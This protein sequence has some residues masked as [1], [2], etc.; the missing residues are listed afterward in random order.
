MSF[1]DFTTQLYAKCQADYV[2]SSQLE[3]VRFG[4]Y[5]YDAWDNSRKE[6]VRIARR[7]FTAG[8][9]SKIFLFQKL[10]QSLASAPLYTRVEINTLTEDIDL[11]TYFERKCPT[12][13]LDQPMLKIVYIP[14]G[15]SYI[16]GLDALPDWLREYE[17]PGAEAALKRSVTHFLKIFHI[18][19]NPEEHTYARTIIFTSEFDCTFLDKMYTMYMLFLDINLE[20]PNITISDDQKG[21][22]EL[23][24]AIFTKLYANEDYA[25]ALGE[26]LTR[27]HAYCSK[28][29]LDYTAF[30]QSLEKML[31]IKQTTELDQNITN[32][33][34]S[35]ER[36]TEELQRLYANLS[37]AHYKKVS[38]KGGLVDFTPF[39]DFI[40]KS[41]EM[42]ILRA[43][44]DS[45]TIRVDTVL[46]YFDVQH[47]NILKKNRSGYLYDSSDF[48]NWLIQ[49][50]FETQRYVLKIQGVYKMAKNSAYTNGF[51]VRA[52]QQPAFFTEC[53]NPHLYFFNCWG[54]SK[55]AF[56]KA[57]AEQSYDVAALQLIAATQQ[58]TLADS[59]VFIRFRRVL[60]G[61]ESSISKQN[62]RVIDTQTNQVMSITDLEQYYKQG[63]NQNVSA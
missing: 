49:Q 21:L 1:S 13:Q 31:Y 55:A 56:F 46:K 40:E 30:K 22:L 32:L 7:N 11:E 27:Y 29:L 23:L 14:S 54:Q 43:T 16:K 20:Q 2:I 10:I 63:A 4:I 48:V 3:A 42:C 45:V 52:L 60:R 50:L 61:D 9:Q 39:F 47:Y 35:I 25:L 24:T 19:G 6:N 41:P 33:Q 34:Q 58:L 59:A 62:I 37:E 57:I 28:S 18:S 26:F 51:E 36:Y 17:K 15:K 53:P 5:S 38:F 8:C 44:T 12:T